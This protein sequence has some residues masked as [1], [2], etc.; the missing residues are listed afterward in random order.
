MVLAGGS[1]AGVSYSGDALRSEG[2]A[3]HPAVVAAAPLL[4][5]IQFGCF[6]YFWKEIGQPSGLAKDRLKGPVSSI[7]AVGFQLS[8]LPIGVERGWI[9]RAAGAERARTILRTLLERND[10]KRFGVYL[11]FPDLDSGGVSLHG[12]EITASTVDH[13]L[14]T[15]GAIPA[16]VYFGGDV[17]DLVDRLVRDANWKAFAVAEKGFLSMGWKPDDPRN[18]AGPGRFLKH[19]WYNASDEERLVY[20]LAVGAPNP[21]FAVEPRLYYELQRK[22]KRHA[23]G[24]PFVVSWPGIPFTYAFSHCWILYGRF[25]A[26]DPGAFGVDAP[27][28]DWH[29]NSR[30]AFLA[31]QARCQEQAA[32]RVL[33]G[34]HG[35]GASACDGRSGYIVPSVR[36]NLSDRE[37]WFDCTLAPY[38]AACAIMFLPEESI[39]ALRAM[40]ELKD[41][42][43][44]PLVWRDPRTG[45]YGFAD[46][47]CLSQKWVSE[48]YIGIDQGPMLLAIENARTG[49]IWRLFLESPHVRRSL[50]RLK[51]SPKH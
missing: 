7:A 20:F 50:E 34:E 49:L 16:G 9:T 1:L 19:H 10:N 21:A 40:R 12:Y 42:A 28:I 15:A 46:A 41:A 4:D 45:G 37:E 51:L 3:P 31:H 43:G 27:G 18:V 30:R 32:C 38:A 35:W 8:A 5:E 47:F 29:E 48:D 11:H 39:A 13:A 33:L 36:P 25:G 14:L 2:H 17:A 24:P 22:Q 44:K 6:Q 23:D 26:D